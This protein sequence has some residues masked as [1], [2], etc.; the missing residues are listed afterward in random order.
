MHLMI[1]TWDQSTPE[2]MVKID[3]PCDLNDEKGKFRELL[4]QNMWT[5]EKPRDDII[6]KVGRCT[7]SQSTHES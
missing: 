6:I 5:S 4:V 2:H 3:V 7:L 1:Q